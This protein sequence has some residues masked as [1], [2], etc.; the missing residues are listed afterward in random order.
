MI[1]QRQAEL[2]DHVAEP[3]VDLGVTGRDLY[4][5]TA[6]LAY[7]DPDYDWAWARYLAAL[8]GLLD[9][10]ADMVR[11]DADGNPGWT[12]LASPSR[13]PEP[14]L[15]VLAQWAGIR[16]W[17][18]LDAPD[19]RA[20][21]GPR[22][23]GLWRGTRDAMIAAARRYYPPRYFDPAY[24]YF[25]ERA[26][27]NPYLL[28]VF[29]Y[30]F[31]EH[32]PELVRAAL[33]GAKPAGLRLIYEVRRGQNWNMVRTV[34]DSWATLKDSYASWRDVLEAEPIGASPEEETR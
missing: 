28:R 7:A 18:A 33:Q 17:D 10:V 16:R 12:A 14:F 13:C 34:N 24:V 23:P 27:G 5:A 3:P 29:T 30:S 32:D 1:A 19:L 9:V 4:A 6:P 15:R 22:A 26:D 2:P 25:E 8:A 31:I 20:L 21:I 11:D